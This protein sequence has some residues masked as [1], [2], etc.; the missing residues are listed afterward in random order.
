MPRSTPSGIPGPESYQETSKYRQQPP[1]P[2]QEGAPIEKVIR[3]QSPEPGHSIPLHFLYEGRMNT[4]RRRILQQ[5][6]R[7]P[8]TA[9]DPGNQEQVPGFLLPVVLKERDPG[10]QTGGTDM[11]E[12]SRDTEALIAHQEQGRNRQSDQGTRYIPG[13]WPSDPFDMGH[14][15]FFST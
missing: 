6:C 9:Q 14:I 8:A 2:C 12:R 5:L 15:Q 11:A 1:P 10:G 7:Y 13:P 3:K 4:N